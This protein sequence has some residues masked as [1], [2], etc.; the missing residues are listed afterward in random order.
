MSRQSL[1]LSFVVALGLLSLMG[2][3]IA[4]GAK[5]PTVAELVNAHDDLQKRL[6]GSSVVRAQQFTE[7]V[8][9]KN[10][11]GNVFG[12]VESEIWRLGDRTHI[13]NWHWPSSQEPY[14]KHPIGPWWR[15]FTVLA[16]YSKGFARVTFVE[17]GDGADTP[18]YV[19]VTPT[20]DSAAGRLGLRAREAGAADL[21]G[22][23]HGDSAPVVV[24]IGGLTSRNIRAATERIGDVECWAVD[25]AGPGGDY[26]LWFD[27]EHAGLLRKA[28]VTKL[29]QHNFVEGKL[30]DLSPGLLSQGRKEDAERPEHRLTKF[31]ITLEVSEIAAEGTDWYPSRGT[32]T[33]TE[34]YGDEHTRIVIQRI[35]QQIRRDAKVLEEHTFQIGPIPDG[36]RAFLNDGVTSG[37]QYQWRGGEVVPAED[38]DATR[39]MRGEVDSLRQSNRSSDH[40]GAA[41]FVSYRAAF[42]PASL[43]LVFCG[44]AALILRNLSKRGATAPR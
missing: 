8:D 4:R 25:G 2:N 6:T 36:T 17:T 12:F 16:P 18:P 19:V 34:I 24:T 39:R 3:V 23:L 7:V 10:E 43:V 42:L 37:V 35:S 27:V 9:P 40:G 38:E 15:Q 5:T 13:L 31:V 20:E 41:G 14:S 22:F 26:T 30:G 44:G 11:D 21:W 28:Q 29:P 1:T 32:I 33:A